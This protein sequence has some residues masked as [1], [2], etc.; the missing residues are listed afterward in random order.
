MTVTKVMWR[1]LSDHNVDN[2]DCV[3]MIHGNRGYNAYD[4]NKKNERGSVRMEVS[5]GID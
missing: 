4:V 3:W 1:M 5:Y 2:K